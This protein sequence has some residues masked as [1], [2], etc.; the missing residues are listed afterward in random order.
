MFR[1]AVFSGHDVDKSSEGR[2]SR[3]P[4]AVSDIASLIWSPIPPRYNRQAEGWLQ[5]A[6]SS[7][8]RYVV[9]I[10]LKQYLPSSCQPF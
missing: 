5:A 8:L 7:K 10:Q 2:L 6:P 4:T 1:G 9:Q 3:W